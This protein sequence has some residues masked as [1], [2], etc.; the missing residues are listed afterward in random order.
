MQNKQRQLLENYQTNTEIVQ[1][2]ESSELKNAEV[3]TETS[4]KQF[5]N[6]EINFLDFVILLNQAI[7]VRSNYIDA[8]WKLN[9]SAI[10]L[11]YPS[12]N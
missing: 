1:Q 3:I 6:G 10:L 8:L 9:E 4:K 11:N 5:L 12:I 7:G 2:Y